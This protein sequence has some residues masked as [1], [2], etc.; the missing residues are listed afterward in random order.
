MRRHLLFLVASC[1]ALSVSASNV[2]FA[3]EGARP[4]GTR[5]RTRI[6][7]NYS[8][9]NKRISV[10]GALTPSVQDA[11]ID[12]LLERK[13]NGSFKNVATKHPVVGGKGRFSTRF[14]RPKRNV[15]RLTASFAGDNDHRPSEA[16]KTFHCGLPVHMV[17]YSPE[18]LPSRTERAVEKIDGVKATTAMSGS[19]FLKSSRAPGGGGVDNPPGSYKI[20]L[21]V[22]FIQP[23]EYARFA[24]EKDK[25]AIRSLGGRRVLLSEGAAELR[26]GH[27]KLKM[28]TTVGRFRSIGSVANSSAQGYEVLVPKPAVNSS[29][30]FRSILIERPPDVGRKRVAR[31]IRRVAGGKPIEIST[32]KEVPYLRAGQLVRPQLFVK[33]AFGEFAMKPASGRS[34]SIQHPWAGQ[35]IKRDGV[36]ILGQV[37][38]HREIFPQLRKA[39]RELRRKGLAHTVTRSNYAGCFNPRFISSYDN[40]DVGPVR[41]LS[42]H[43][44][45]IALDINAGSNPFGQ[46]PHQ[47]RRFVR[48][49]KKWGFTWGGK[50]ALPDGMHFEWERWP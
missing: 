3:A 10:R 33:K 28:R 16:D 31:K 45:G 15:C 27:S 29:V 5:T 9:S 25:E 37:T 4:R 8:K 23:E 47:N 18:Q 46:R 12:V 21:D 50:W 48:I 40:S 35:N 41:R 43:S 7:L 44:W 49:M 2:S 20:P 42:R 26:D 32:E 24:N 13:S 17:T 38:C 22:T 6:E 30:A 39:M 19:L 14:Q 1:A 34:I 36:P 11:E